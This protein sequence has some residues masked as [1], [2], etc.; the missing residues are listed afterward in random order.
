MPEN[1]NDEDLVIDPYFLI[2]AYCNSY[3]PM[4]DSSEGEIYW[5][6]PDPR[7]VFP[8]YSLKKPRS[9]RQLLNKNIY[10]FKIDCNFDSVIRQCALSRQ[11]TWINGI[12]INTY[13]YLNQNGIAHSVEVYRD[14]E[15]CGGLYGVSIGAAFFGESMFNTEPNTAKL[16][17][18]HLIDILKAQGFL[19]LD[20][21][22]INHFT[23]QLGAE[24]IPKAKYM[25]LLKEA[26]SLKCSFV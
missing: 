24:E 22:Y 10:N 5:H 3:F 21:Q 15:L 14:N 23:R 25:A 4:A 8:I 26:I 1:E 16:A 12:I 20:S 17:F 11:D 19:L 18:Y 6:S 9:V 13:N 2:E 7:A